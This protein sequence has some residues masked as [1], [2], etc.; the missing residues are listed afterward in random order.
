M[1][2]EG[3]CVLANCVIQLVGVDAAIQLLRVSH[4]IHGCSHTA[5]TYL[6]L[7][8]VKSISYATF[9]L[10]LGAHLT[11]SFSAVQ[12]VDYIITRKPSAHQHEENCF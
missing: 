6:A 1:N 11:Y 10:V 5:L 7:S 3:V 2:C 4:M 12:P 8:S 9:D